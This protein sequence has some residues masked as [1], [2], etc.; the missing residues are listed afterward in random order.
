MAEIH[1]IGQL[2][3]ASGFENENVFCKWGIFAGRSWELLE[4]SDSGQTHVDHPPEGDMAVWSHP[5]DVHYS[6]KSLTGW[7]KLHFQVWKQ[8]MHGRN[9]ICGYGFCHIP[10]APGMFEVECPTWALDG[11]TSERVAAFFVGGSPKLKMEEVVYSPADRF[12][13]TTHAAGVVHVQLH[14]ITKDFARHNIR[15]Q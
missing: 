4:G 15:Y 13:L 12:R 10:M 11:S 14:V 5:V 8:D 1:V 9:D 7:P 6:T 3:G 2:V